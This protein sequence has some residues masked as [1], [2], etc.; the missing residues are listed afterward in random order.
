MML[1][2]KHLLLSSMFLVCSF[3]PLAIAD[4]RAA[5]QRWDRSSAM[6]AAGSVNIAKAIYG[7]GDI[8]SLA[9]GKATVSKLRYLEARSDWPLPARESAIYQFTRSLADLPR[10][11]VAAEVM[12]HLQN[13][14]AK[15]LV[16]HEEHPDSY[17]PLFNIRGAA[18]GVE[19]GWQ[20]TEFSSEAVTLIET[21]PVALVSAFAQSANHNQKSG[22]LDALRYAHMADV[23]EVQNTALQFLEELP[24]LTGMVSLTAAIT[25]DT[26][27]IQQLL[28]NGRGAGLSAALVQLDKQLQATE[29]A[30]LLGIAIQQ[31][32]S[33]N[34]ALAIAAWWPRLKHD[35]VIREL[36]IGTLS[37]PGLGASAALALSQEP[38]IQ[39]IRD[40]QNTARG[41]STAARRAQM[42]LDINRARLVGDTQP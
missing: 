4:D 38:D 18:A 20:R 40:L 19:N 21:D 29:T 23:M 27:A 5:S 37:D 8:S 32:P 41:N 24:E 36:L 3:V 1:I 35:P 30:E 12:R 2:R 7:L 13:Y 11:A 25:S 42:A 33:S 22:Y 31:A 17:I 10:D 28:I 14:Q 34:A 16:S 6:T 9:D 15:T 39:T 26:Y